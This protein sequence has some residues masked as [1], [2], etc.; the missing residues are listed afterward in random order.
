MRGMEGEGG[1]RECLAKEDE[2][3]GKVSQGWA[4]ERRVL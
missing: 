3:Q 2:A 4:T 1:D